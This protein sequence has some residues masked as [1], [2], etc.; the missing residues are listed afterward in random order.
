MVAL[1]LIVGEKNNQ[2]SHFK[3]KEQ[4]AQAVCLFI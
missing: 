3:V 1:F 4:C 2:Q